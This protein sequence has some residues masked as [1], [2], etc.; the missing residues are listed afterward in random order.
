VVVE[1]SEKEIRA[2]ASAVG[3]S[4]NLPQSVGRLMTHE[5]NNADLLPSAANLLFT[6]STFT[7]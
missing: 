1:T 7:R 5:P 4:S 3:Q 2:R 6:L